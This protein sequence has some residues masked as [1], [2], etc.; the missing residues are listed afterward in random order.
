[1]QNTILARNVVGVSCGG[2]AITSLGNNIDQDGSCGLAD[3]TDITGGSVGL[4]I[5]RDNGGPTMTHM[6]SALSPALDVG[7]NPASLLPDQRGM[8]RTYGAGT[9]MGAVEVQPSGSDVIPGP[10]G[11]GLVGLALLSLRRRR[12]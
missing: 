1:M 9:D 12:S 10:A 2:S 3:P 6:L 8:A 5:L 4:D 7:S 11:L